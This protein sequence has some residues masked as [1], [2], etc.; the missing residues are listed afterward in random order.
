MSTVLKIKYLMSDV[1]EERV[2][3]YFK[4]FFDK[5]SCPFQPNSEF[6]RD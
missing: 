2:V 6:V 1:L 4:A 3:H 5:K